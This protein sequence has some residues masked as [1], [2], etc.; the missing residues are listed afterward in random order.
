MEGE[1]RPAVCGDG[2]RQDGLDVG[3][4]RAVLDRNRMHV[5]LVPTLRLVRRIVA[6]PL[7]LVVQYGQARHRGVRGAVRRRE[8][9]GGLAEQIG[10]VGLAVRQLGL[11]LRLRE[12]GQVLVIDG[13]S[14]DVATLCD[15]VL[16]LRGCHVSPDA[17][18]GVVLGRV[19]D[20]VHRRRVAEGLHHGQA[21]LVCALPA[22]VELERDEWAGEG[23]IGC[24]K[25]RGGGSTGPSGCGT[26]RAAGREEREA[27]DEHGQQFAVHCQV[28]LSVRD[29]T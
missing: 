25:S 19:S 6:V 3:Q 11:N 15:P 2:V 9:G 1:N 23:G 29:I 17:V 10:Q 5:V 13:V 27:S 18:I 21:V 16:D 20:D 22:V 7:I 24:R 8:E 12:R 26:G 14:A 4:R 28:L